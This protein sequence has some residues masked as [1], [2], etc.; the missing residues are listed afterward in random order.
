MLLAMKL[1]KQGQGTAQ[2]QQEAMEWEVNTHAQDLGSLFLPPLVLGMS[3]QGGND[4]GI[5]VHRTLSVI[6]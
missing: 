4:G 1:E 2:P 6:A 5:L 3:G